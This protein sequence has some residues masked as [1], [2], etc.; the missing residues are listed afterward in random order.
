MPGYE[1]S[2]RTRQGK[3]FR[4]GELGAVSSKDVAGYILAVVIVYGYAGLVA[5]MYYWMG[6]T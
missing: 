3:E 6:L 2:L 1:G 4:A 5:L